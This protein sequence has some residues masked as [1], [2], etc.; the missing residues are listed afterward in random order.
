[1]FE[2][3]TIV[4]KKKRNNTPLQVHHYR[5]KSYTNYRSH[6]VLVQIGEA[7]YSWKTEV[8]G[9]KHNTVTI[10]CIV[11]WAIKSIFG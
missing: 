7:Y 9:Y 8:T 5:F 10:L 3:N 2:I 4:K 1:M 11:T 6:V